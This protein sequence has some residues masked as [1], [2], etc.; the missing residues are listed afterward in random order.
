MEG[1]EVLRAALPR[2]RLTAIG[3]APDPLG[4]ITLRT[5]KPV[6]ARVVRR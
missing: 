5:A 1:L 3:D 4:R 2:F 6:I